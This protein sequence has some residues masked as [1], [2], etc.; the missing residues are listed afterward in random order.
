MHTK[1]C[2]G[3][4]T[5]PIL[6]AFSFP[7]SFLEVRAMSKESDSGSVRRGFTLIELLV[8]IAIIAVLI[9]LLLPAVQAA[10]E[11]ARRIQCTNNIKQLALAAANYE[12]A[13]QTFPLG[14]NSINCFGA[15]SVPN[16]GP[17]DGWGQFARLLNFAE[18]LAVYNAINFSDTPY[19]ARNSTA[20]GVGVSIL[21]CPSD[22]TIAGLRFFEQCAGWDC[23]TVGITYTNYAGMLGTYC[24]SDGRQP[25]TT[26][27][28]MEDGMYPDVGVPVTAFGG[29]GFTRAPTKYSSITDGT[30]NT[31]GFV[32]T[33]HGKYSQ[34]G[35]SATG[36]CD[37]NGAGWWA[38][39]DY[40]DSTVTSF[41]PPNFAIPPVYYTTGNW[42][43]P[44]GCDAGNNIPPMSSNS[45]HPAGVNVGFADGSVHF[46]KNSIST[47]NSLGIK[48]AAA[49]GANCVIP[50]TAL[51]GVW[52]SLSTINGGEVI[53][54]D[55]Y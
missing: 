25:N 27:I 7:F 36:G 15:G 28:G 12:S 31:M 45:F 48:R 22:G 33:A 29:L 17:C 40:E 43:N 3:R 8:V 10:R 23:T 54:A 14:R 38:D 13:N 46:I 9:A 5:I 39:A 21:W 30:S 41:Y 26:E 51:R 1:E 24:P 11:A 32:E 2:E 20:E 42:A 4:L 52:Q 53:S 34:F 18:Q 35:C 19:G 55:Q 44:D 47:W 37:Y 50:V 16:G 49:G 6:T